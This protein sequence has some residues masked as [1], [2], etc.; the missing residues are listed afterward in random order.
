MNI[1]IQGSTTLPSH[2]YK[3]SVRINGKKV[4]IYQIKKEDDCVSGFIE[5]VTGA[6]FAVEVTNSKPKDETV[7][8]IDVFS[9]GEEIGSTFNPGFDKELISCRYTGKNG[10]QDFTMKKLQVAADGDRSHAAPDE[11]GVIRVELCSCTNVEEF[12]N[13]DFGASRITGSFRKFDE[14]VTDDVSHETVFGK[15]KKR[16]L[17][18]SWVCTGREVIETF[19]FIYLSKEILERKLSIEELEKLHQ[20]VRALEIRRELLKKQILKEENK[21]LE[22]KLSKIRAKK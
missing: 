12:R 7:D 15:I 9:D 13:D 8:V 14:S 20:N 3:V 16:K 5:A 2:H 1:T 10:S 18:S 6:K 11:L 17:E 19:K 4:P 21:A 22:D